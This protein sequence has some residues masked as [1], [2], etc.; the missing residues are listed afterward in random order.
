M[1]VLSLLI[2][3]AE[4]ILCLIACWYWRKAA[5]EGERLR[6]ALKSARE[7][8]LV[9]PELGAPPWN[10]QEVKQL[11]DGVGEVIWGIEAAAAE[12]E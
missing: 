6:C 2:V 3:W 4:M 9:L 1:L 8:L 12:E 5:L 11:N 7:S 10:E